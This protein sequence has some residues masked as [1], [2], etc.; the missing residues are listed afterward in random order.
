MS[1]SALVDGLVPVAFSATGAHLLAD[2]QG[3]DTSAAWTVDLSSAKPVVRDLDGIADGNI[4]DG[5][6][7]NGETVL[8][9]NGFEGT[10]HSLETIPWGGGK[11]TVLVKHGGNGS[12][13]Y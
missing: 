6:S 12:W 7:G 11:P 13:N 9:D 3:T 1:V 10:A 5:I 2:F 8:V 4:P